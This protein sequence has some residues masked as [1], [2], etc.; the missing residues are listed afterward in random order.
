MLSGDG[1]MTDD[2]VET[3]VERFAA[4]GTWI[5]LHQFGRAAPDA[6]LAAR[7]AIE[8]VDDALPARM[9]EFD[10]Q[11]VAVD[12]G[13]GPGAEFLMANPI[14]NDVACAFRR[15]RRNDLAFNGDGSAQWAHIALPAPLRIARPI[16]TLR[17]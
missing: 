11:L 3:G 6:L 12:L 9:I 17:S 16:S 1:Q 4:M 15:R 5:E 13:Y 14:A 8:A 7:R 2:M 10:G